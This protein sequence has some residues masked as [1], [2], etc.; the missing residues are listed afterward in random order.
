MYYFYLFECK[1]KSLYSGI[2]ND[3]VKREKAHNTGTGSKYVRAH[4]GGKIIYT[5]KIRTL[6]K[7]L[8]REAEVKKFSRKDKLD[9]IKLAKTKK[10]SK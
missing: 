7:A 4:G 9:I 8:K 3:I 1:D 10:S 6:S 5:E 2:T